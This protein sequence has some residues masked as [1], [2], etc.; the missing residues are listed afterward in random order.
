MYS[1]RAEA[2]KDNW[3]SRRHKTP[4]ANTEAR[5]KYQS[6][7]AKPEVTKRSPREQLAELDRRLGKGV[8]AKAERARL[9][10][11]IMNR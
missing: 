10:A 7:K 5:E 3:F 1:T 11:L 8:G 2:G 9:L 4:D 6:R